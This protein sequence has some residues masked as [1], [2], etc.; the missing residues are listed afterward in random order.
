[1]V[2]DYGYSGW[3]VEIC[4]VYTRAYNWLA[5]FEPCALISLCA[6]LRLAA[7]AME[8][9]LW[10][11]SEFIGSPIFVLPVIFQAVLREY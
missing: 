10:G 8:P 6:L 4:N 1:M 9:I 11:R 7:A 3:G 5:I 2:Y